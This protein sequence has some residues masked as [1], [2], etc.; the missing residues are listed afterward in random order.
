MRSTA[1]SKTSH[2]LEGE[3]S[4]NFADHT[5]PTPHGAHPLY[6]LFTVN[7]PKI[8]QSE[9]RKVIGQTTLRVCPEIN[10]L[11]FIKL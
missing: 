11:T 9:K 4:D 1:R 8:Y 3:G 6:R 10:H 7:K 5:H 2:L